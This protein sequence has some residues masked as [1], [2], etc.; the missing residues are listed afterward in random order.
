MFL[1]FE[2]RGK[3]GLISRELRLFACTCC[4]HISNLITD[5]RSWQAVNIAERYA[6]GNASRDELKAAHDSVELAVESIQQR[7]KEINSAVQV[8]KPHRSGTSE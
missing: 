7:I 6:D 3:Q 5:E 8:D 4:R 1:D 2:D